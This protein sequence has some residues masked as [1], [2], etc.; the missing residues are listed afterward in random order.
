MTFSTFKGEYD[1][2]SDDYSRIHKIGLRD[3]L[4]AVHA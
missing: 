4:G 2:S 1:N 3:G